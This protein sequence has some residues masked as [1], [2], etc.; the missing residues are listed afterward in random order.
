MN[1]GNLGQTITME[2]PQVVALVQYLEMLEQRQEGEEK[3][4]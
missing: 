3:K 4:R 2:V 1:R